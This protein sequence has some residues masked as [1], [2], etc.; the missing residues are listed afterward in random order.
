VS[1]NER[2]LHID[3]GDGLRWTVSED[4][5]VTE[6]GTVGLSRKCDEAAEDPYVRPGVSDSGAPKGEENSGWA[7]ER[8]SDWCEQRNLDQHTCK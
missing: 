7:Y 8:M 6:L 4:R 5:R 1:E 3:S 2:D